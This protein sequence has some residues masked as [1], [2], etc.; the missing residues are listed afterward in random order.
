MSSNEVEFNIYSARLELPACCR[1]DV[2]VLVLAP[3]KL[4]FWAFLDPP[5]PAFSNKPSKH[6]NKADKHVLS[7]AWFEV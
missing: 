3:L 6:A 2:T 7:G 5:Q 4:E 1:S